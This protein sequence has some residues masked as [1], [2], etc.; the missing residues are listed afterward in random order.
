M[1]KLLRLCQV[2]LSLCLKSS[3]LIL[4]QATC[5]Q[6]LLPGLHHA[7]QHPQPRLAS[8]APQLRLV[9]LERAQVTLECSRIV[10]DGTHR[11]LQLCC[12]GLQRLSLSD[13][14]LGGRTQARSLLEVLLG[15]SRLLGGLDV[16]QQAH[17]RGGAV[18]Q[19]R[20]LRHQ[21][22]VLRGERPQLRLSLGDAPGSILQPLL[23][24]LLSAPQRTLL[25]LGIRVKPRTPRD[26]RSHGG[27]L[28]SGLR[29]RLALLHQ[30]LTLL[31]QGLL[32]LLGG[33]ARSLDSGGLRL[34]L[35]LL[36]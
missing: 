34:Q 7:H 27:H 17:G 6:Q 13:S 24:L 29:K 1:C 22:T 2:S 8:C 26:A 16:G 31:L 18:R 11:C 36:R 21:V 30:N 20:A 4:T 33:C 25:G 10:L 32:P 5:L 35:A 14:G 12:L 3:H 19:L 28:L 15:G 23:R 9:S